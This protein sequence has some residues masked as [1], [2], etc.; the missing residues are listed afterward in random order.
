MKQQMSGV[1]K[2]MPLFDKMNHFLPMYGV[3]R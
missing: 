2:H 3:G 1:L